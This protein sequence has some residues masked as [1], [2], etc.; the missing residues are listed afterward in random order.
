MSTPILEKM[1]SLD[2][3]SYFFRDKQMWSLENDAV[4]GMNLLLGDHT[5]THF[6]PARSLFLYQ[7]KSLDALSYFS[8]MQV[9]DGIAT[10]L[11]FFYEHQNPSSPEQ[12]LLIPKKFDSLI[13]K[14]WIE[15]IFLY[16]H[17]TIQRTESKRNKLVLIVSALDEK[18][19]S[20]PGLDRL[21]LKLTSYN[22]FS[23][24]NVIVMPQ[25]SLFAQ[26]KIMAFQIQLVLKIQKAWPHAQIKL[27]NDFNSSTLAD[28]CFIDLNEY[29]FYYGHS[30]LTDFFLQRG[31]LD[32][33]ALQN[34]K[35]DS[36]LK[37]PLSFYH[38]LHLSKP[39]DNNEFNIENFFSTM[40]KSSIMNQEI[41]NHRPQKIDCSNLIVAPS[42][43]DLAWRLSQDTKSIF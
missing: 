10:L 7:L 31:A 8:P 27:L 13:P 2:L 11:G 25:K 12:Q 17:K 26:D 19:I 29:S 23:E 14:S 35:Q 37:I 16:E 24:V 22:T 39:D 1:M 33:S 32:F 36:L 42:I 6:S 5:N 15:Q 21:I 30:A 20:L 4:S 38:E 18:Q 28:H 34:T 43:N 41:K 9:K 3:Q 40:R